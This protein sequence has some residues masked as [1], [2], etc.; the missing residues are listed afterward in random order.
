MGQVVTIEMVKGLVGSLQS[1]GSAFNCLLSLVLSQ[2]SA[3]GSRLVQRSIAYFLY[4]SVS[5]QQSAG[6]A[7]RLPTADHQLSQQLPRI[8]HSSLSGLFATEK[9]GYFSNALIL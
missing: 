8:G 1:A 5:S 9:F 3:V 4:S 6:P 7:F 2:R